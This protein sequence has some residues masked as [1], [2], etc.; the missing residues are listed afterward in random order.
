MPTYLATPQQKEMERRGLHYRRSITANL[1]ENAEV[2]RFLSALSPSEQ[3]M[4]ARDNRNV[5]KFIVFGRHPDF[6]IGRN[7]TAKAESIK[8]LMWATRVKEWE[9]VAGSSRLGSVYEAVLEAGQRPP[10]APLCVKFVKGVLAR[11]PHPVPSVEYSRMSRWRKN[12]HLS[13]M[14][15]QILSHVRR[16]CR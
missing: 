11:I 3:Q 7:G 12:T 1:L 9:L 8:R 6:I 16:P 10:P 5:F 4:L 14:H 2:R 13:E 15:S